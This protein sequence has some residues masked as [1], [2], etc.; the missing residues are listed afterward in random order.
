MKPGWL[1]PQKAIL[2]LYRSMK[3]V[4]LQSQ[5][6]PEQAT[7]DQQTCFNAKLKHI[8]LHATLSDDHVCRFKKWHPADRCML[9]TCSS[10]KTWTLLETLSMWNP[11]PD[12]NPTSN[13]ARW[14][15]TKCTKPTPL[16]QSILNMDFSIHSHFG[17]IILTVELQSA[18]P[19]CSQV[20][21]SIKMTCLG[22]RVTW[23]GFVIYTE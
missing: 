9:S 1:I 3:Q 16:S 22:E 21:N 12:K 8:S 15:Y 6:S 14:K 23:S 2:H 4:L 20:L 13:Y 18:L 5:E 10:N 11:N 17:A 19:F 7:W